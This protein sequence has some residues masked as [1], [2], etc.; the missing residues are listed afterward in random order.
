MPD[1]MVEK[2]QTLDDAID[3]ALIAWGMGW[4]MDGVMAC[5]KEA[6]DRAAL[7]SASAEPVAWRT[8]RH[9]QEIGHALTDAGMT[10]DEWNRLGFAVEP[11]YTRPPSEAAIR[12]DERADVDRTAAEMAVS[13]LCGAD[14]GDMSQEWQLSGHQI[15]NLIVMGIKHATAIRARGGR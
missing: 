5:L 10:A 3:N 6:K 13:S 4:D 15:I 11:L 1:E 12:A 2:A 7:S 9:P 8:K 14:D